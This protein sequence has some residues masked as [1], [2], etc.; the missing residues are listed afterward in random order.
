MCYSSNTNKLKST[1][2]KHVEYSVP[3]FENVYFEI[4]DT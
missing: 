2:F 3:H 1:A 4:Y